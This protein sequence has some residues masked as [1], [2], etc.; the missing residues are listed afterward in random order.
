MT[1]ENTMSDTPS[2]AA[3]Q[4]RTLVAGQGADAR[5]IAYRIQ[6]G[7]TP[8]VVWLG[9]YRSDMRGTKAEH[10]SGLCG[11]EGIGFCR[12]DYSGHGESGGRFEDG[13]ISRWT[14]DAAAVID[15]AT[16]GAMVLV[17]SSMGAWIA[18]RLIQAALR[19]KT[20]SR[21]AGLLLIAPAPDFTERLVKPKLTSDQ[22]EAIE[23]DSLLKVP[24]RYGDEPDLYTRALVED[25]AN[26]LVMDD[27]IETG[28]PVR[29]IQ[30]MA[31]PD[32]PYTHALE[33]VALLPGDG[34]T[35]TL[36]RDGDHRLS[37][38]QDLDLIG[39]AMRDLVAEAR[40]N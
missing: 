12:L 8:T 7:A 19:S 31:D 6:P 40:S 9:G 26:N 30:G 10:L 28:C 25:G 39:R 27:L 2:V 14:A 24:S 36:V 23:R 16:D 18:L 11:T 17:G 38:P 1:R 20:D 22:W 29:I 3:E 35:L 33:L 34:V 5:D 15:A 4:P 21:I 32:V 13:T 37:R